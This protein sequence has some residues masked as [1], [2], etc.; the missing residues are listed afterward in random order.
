MKLG[1]S[2][3]MLRTKRVVKRI[4]IFGFEMVSNNMTTLPTRPP[5]A[6]E[7]ERERRPFTQGE[8]MR[9]RMTEGKFRLGRP[10]R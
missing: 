7:R 6:A 8:S 3:E 1:W 5:E 10:T 9:S 4:C 2:P